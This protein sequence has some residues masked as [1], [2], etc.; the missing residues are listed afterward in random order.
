M[1]EDHFTTKKEEEVLQ[2]AET[3]TTP[4][5]EAQEDE[6]DN[7]LRKSQEEFKTIEPEIPE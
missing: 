1:V 3:T 7:I 6:V 2:V 4:E 5:A